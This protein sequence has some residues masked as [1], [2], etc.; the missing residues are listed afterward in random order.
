MIKTSNIKNLPNYG[1]AQPRCISWLINPLLQVQ[2]TL[3]NNC[4]KKYFMDKQPILCHI[5]N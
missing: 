1:Q 4:G 3:D 2:V 5:K